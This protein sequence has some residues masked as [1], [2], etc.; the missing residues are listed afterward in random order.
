MRITCNACTAQYNLP[1][2]KVRGRRVK[3]RCKRC[4]EGIIVDGTQLEAPPSAREFEEEATRV[5]A[6]PSEAAAMWTVNLSDDEQGD[7]TE[8]ELIAGWQAGIVT[9]DAYVWREGMDD[10]AALLDVPE[11]ASLLASVPHPEPTQ[12]APVAPAAAQAEAPAPAV[13]TPVAPKVA[14]AFASPPR[15]ATARSTSSPAPSPFD[16]VFAPPSAARREKPRT[17]AATAREENSVLFSLD[18]LKRAAETTPSGERADIAAVSG[19]ASEDI[20]TMGSPALGGGN[21]APLIDIEAPAPVAAPTF[22]QASVPAASGAPPEKSRGGLFAIIALTALVAGGG[23]VAATQLMGTKESPSAATSASAERVGAS[24]EPS[25]AAS[26]TSESDEKK[27]VADEAANDDEN[28]AAEDAKEATPANEPKSAGDADK[29]K[30]ES[31]A[32]ATAPSRAAAPS[33]QTSPSQPS[34]PSR[35]T[36]SSGSGSTQSESDSNKS[37]KEAATKA[38]PPPF[39]TAAAKASLSSAASSAKG[40]ASAGGPSGR[41]KVQVTFATSGRVTSANVVSGPFGGTSVGGCVAR[42]FRGARVPAFSG[43]PVTVAKSFSIPQK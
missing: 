22:A 30:E 39:S 2:E 41:G 1:D 24:A 40:C 23:A 36:T 7:M 25:A 11:L 18:A 4:S 6:P 17:A 33:H 8:E 26:E 43:G 27:P 14:T 28:T 3:V 12:G 16:N 20:L 32:Q 5:M 38:P 13:E 10:W 35:T 9:E 29:G 21:H 37:S 15:A 19:R 34:T 31:S 42:K